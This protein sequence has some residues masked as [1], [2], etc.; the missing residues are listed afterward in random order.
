MLRAAETLGFGACQARPIAR[1]RTQKNLRVCV[2][3]AGR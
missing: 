3:R 2:G 1:L